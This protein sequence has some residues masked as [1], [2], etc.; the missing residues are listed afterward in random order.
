MF[1]R[2]TALRYLFSWTI[3][4]KNCVSLLT[5]YDNK[6]DIFTAL[7]ESLYSEVIET[8]ITLGAYLVVSCGKGH[9]I[10]V[11]YIHC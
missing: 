6:H 2:R 5:A 7:Q 8:E 3:W 1:A 9:R 4:F 11:E 10:L